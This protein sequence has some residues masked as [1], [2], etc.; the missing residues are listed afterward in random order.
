MDK[1]F[2]NMEIRRGMPGRYRVTEQEVEAEALLPTADEIREF[3][4]EHPSLSRDTS[5]NDATAQPEG[6]R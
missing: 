3:E 6:K 4:N 1:G 5:E 2:V